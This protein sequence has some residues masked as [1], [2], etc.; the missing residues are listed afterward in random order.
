MKWKKKYQPPIASCD[1]MSC[2]NSLVKHI[3]FLWCWPS[4]LRQIE[5]QTV[6]P[7]LP[8]NLLCVLWSYFHNAVHSD[9]FRDRSATLLSQFIHNK[10]QKTM[11]GR[12]SLLR[13]FLA[14]P[15]YSKLLPGFSGSLDKRSRQ[16]ELFSEYDSLVQCGFHFSSSW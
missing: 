4:R 12:W 14:D 16:G 2:N 8:R 3:C 15:E 7:N 6:G 9:G 1:M 10:R 5:P 11:F 13:F